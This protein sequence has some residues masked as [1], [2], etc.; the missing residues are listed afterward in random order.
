MWLLGRGSTDFAEVFI[1][2]AS[3][4]SHCPPEQ[5]DIGLGSLCPYFSL[6]R[7]TVSKDLF[8]YLGEAGK[9]IPSFLSHALL[10]LGSN[11]VK[12]KRAQ[13]HASHL[14]LPAQPCEPQRRFC[15]H[16]FASVRLH[17]ATRRSFVL[18]VRWSIYSLHLHCVLGT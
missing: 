11:Q 12:K 4:P 5:S 13:T 14:P 8:I 1:A 17:R 18:H 2:R 7:Y 10:S 9:T 3:F 6:R 16:T 15:Q